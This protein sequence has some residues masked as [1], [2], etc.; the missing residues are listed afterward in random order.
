M[1]HLATPFGRCVCGYELPGGIDDFEGS[2]AHVASVLVAE[3]GL[4]Q[5]FMQTFDG[6]HSWWQ[7]P[8]QWAPNSEMT[9][10][11]PQEAL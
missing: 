2:A 10:V 8:S 1:A 5:H 3:L 7:T 11:F 6:V 9:G 4:Q